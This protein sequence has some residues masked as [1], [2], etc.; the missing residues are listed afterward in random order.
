MGKHNKLVVGLDVGTTK[1]GAVIGEVSPEGELE[2]IGLGHRPSKGLRKGVIVEIESARDAIMAV[3]EDAEVMAGARI[4]AAY[5]GISGSQ[6]V[7]VMAEGTL[8]LRSQA[9]TARE[10]QQVVEMAQSPL[11]TRDREILHVVPQEF[12]LDGEEGI[13]NP[14]G[15]SGAK[16]GVRVKVM[17]APAPVMES[18]RQVMDLARVEIRE[19]V[20]RQ[21]ASAEGVLTEDEKERGVGVIDVGGSSSDIVVYRGSLP[22][23]IR[24]L[25]VGGNHVT[26]DLAVGLRTPVSEAERLKQQFGCALLS[27]VKAEEM[28]E[29]APARGKEGR[30]FPR[31]F[32]AEIIEARVEEIFAMALHQIQQGGF[33]PLLSGGIVLTGGAS[34]MPGMVQ[35]A[36]AVFEM[37]VRMGLPRDIGGLTDLISSPTYAAAVGLV[38]YGRRR[39]LGG[40]SPRTQHLRFGRYFRRVAHWVQEFF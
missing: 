28:V 16:L 33:Y 25:G 14:I 31:K 32:L 22:Q 5:V 2:V 8:E 20:A 13:A 9:I 37:P 24:S 7:E 10:V 27:L 6:V 36:E 38:K 26:H 23:Y 11:G 18:L 40:E 4:D 21:L 1:I 3:L 29:V 30:S 39:L 35:A 15:L 12:T 34:V 17:S 19:V